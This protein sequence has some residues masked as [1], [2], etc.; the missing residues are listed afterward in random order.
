MKNFKT[1]LHKRFHQHREEDSTYA[2]CWALLTAHLDDEFIAHDIVDQYLEDWKK[3]DSSY[4]VD[5]IAA[6]SAGY[7]Q[8][9]E[10]I[11]RLKQLTNQL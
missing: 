8:A 1:D 5:S 3:R 11:N 10:D 4:L 7:H 9:V 6:I 2:A